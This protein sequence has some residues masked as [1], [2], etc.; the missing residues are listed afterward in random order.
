[1]TGFSR[2]RCSRFGVLVLSTFALVLV[3]TPSWAH[4]SSLTLLDY[5][6]AT[7]TEAN[8]INSSGAIVGSYSADGQQYHGFLWVDG[9]F[10]TV[11]VPNATST[12]AHGVS[13]SGRIVG[14]Y[15]DSAGVHG[16]QL[17]KSTYTTIDFPD[18]AAFTVALGISSKGVVGFYQPLGGLL[19]HGFVW[20]GHGFTTVDVLA[21]PYTSASGIDSTGRI[22]GL[23][24]DVTDEEGGHGFLRKGSSFTTIDFPGARFTVAEG[25]SSSGGIVGW[26]KDASSGR[27]YG[28][29][30]PDGITAFTTINACGTGTLANG[31]SPGDEDEHDGKSKARIVGTCF[32]ETGS[33]GFLLKR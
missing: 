23:Y 2:R 21:A 13:D 11:D 17:A 25:I 6:G 16:F 24:G 27:T 20:D 26:Y 31:I 32:D 22:V 29:F 9:R 4:A 7:L 12:W 19:V 28:F 3:A 18:A 14:A 5:P 8:G 33:H 15:K 1:M 30:T 10:T